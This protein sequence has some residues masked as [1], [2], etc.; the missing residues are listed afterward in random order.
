MLREQ[1]LGPTGVGD[2]AGASRNGRLDGREGEPGG[3]S[4]LRVRAGEITPRTADPEA[5]DHE[6]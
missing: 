6:L 5:T 4:L 1:T 2:E 3:G